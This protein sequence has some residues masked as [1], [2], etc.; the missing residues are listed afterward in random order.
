MVQYSTPAASMSAPEKQ[1][2]QTDVS[3]MFKCGSTLTA[4]ARSRIYDIVKSTVLNITKKVKTFVLNHEI[5][6]MG[7]G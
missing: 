6:Y 2:C 4:V 7:M 3:N 1:K 5:A